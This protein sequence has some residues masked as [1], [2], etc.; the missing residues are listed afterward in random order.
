MNN[1]L[2]PTIKNLIMCVLKRE[3]CQDSIQN[4]KD[5]LEKLTNYERVDSIEDV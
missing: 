4:K 5:M 1:N 3:L 2:L